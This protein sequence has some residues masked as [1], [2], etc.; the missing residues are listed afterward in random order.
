M[1]FIV[2]TDRVHRHRVNRRQDL[3]CN[4]HSV[5]KLALSKDISFDNADLTLNT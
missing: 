2:Q 1:S 4:I 5:G 3:Q